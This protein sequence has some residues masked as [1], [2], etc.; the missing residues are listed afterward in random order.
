MPFHTLLAGV[1]HSGSGG[2]GVAAVDPLVRPAA[3]HVVPSNADAFR[4]LQ[5]LVLAP[6][7]AAP[8]EGPATRR[9]AGRGTKGAGAITGRR[10]RAN[11]AAAKDGGRKDATGGLRG[12]LVVVLDEIDGLLASHASGKGCPND[13][14]PGFCHMEELQAGVLVDVGGLL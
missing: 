5:K 7:V 3:E 6:P 13:L 8:D 2:C 14:S 11:K 12:M 1:N 4:E 10:Q 9:G